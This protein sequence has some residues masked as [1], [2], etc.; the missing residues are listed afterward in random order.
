[1]GEGSSFGEIDGAGD[2]S[3]RVSFPSLFALAS[4]KEAWVTDLRV[5]F[6]VE[7]GWNPRFSRPLNDWEVETVECF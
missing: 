5:H 4:S 6:S 3:L 7:S 2:E 1:M